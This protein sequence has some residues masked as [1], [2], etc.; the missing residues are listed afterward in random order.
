MAGRIGFD[1]KRVF[2]NQSGLGNY[3]R[4][5]I[6]SLIKY[7]PEFTYLL[8]SPENK[9]KDLYT[10]GAH[11]QLISP[12]R[13]L[14]QKFPALW[15]HYFIS[16][17]LKKEKINVFHGLSNELPS[18]I[19]G[20][21]IGKI[22]TI[23]DLIFLRYPELY[24]FIDR[25]IYNLKFKK[26]SQSADIIIAISEATKRDLIEFYK[27]PEQKIRVSY[28]SCDPSY[29]TFYPEIEKLEE[30]KKKFN[31][32]AQFM[33]YVG[34]VEERKNLLT[35]LM[36][37]TISP[38][39]NKIP[40]VVVGGKRAEYFKKVKEFIVKHNLQDLVIF[41]PRVDDEELKYFYSLASLFIYPSVYEG[42][43]L[44]VL[45]SLLMGTPV[46]TSN[47]SSLA[48]AAGPNSCLL[49][50]PS[51]ALEMAFSIES[52]LQSEEK[53]KNM[54]QLGLE[55]AQQFHPE[56]TSSKI[57]SLYKELF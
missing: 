3:A 13:I 43:G 39:T 6:S 44:P 54:V 20:T 36:S 24:P 46:I 26:A 57:V 25:K 19:N 40:L 48:E 27:I 5:L 18:N 17:S 16:E 32:P 56:K 45:E 42:F 4:T 11:A 2:F 14:H 41:T 21:G 37:M 50:N 34:T 28:Q 12:Q 49:Q 23:H 53:R 29:F 9:K 22:V 51:D 30:V 55:W 7:H 52:L 10:L 35:I 31:L 1:A 33:L 8:F 47:N 15:R 38:A